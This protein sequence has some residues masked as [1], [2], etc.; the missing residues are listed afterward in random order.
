MQARV[1]LHVVKY[2]YSTGNLLELK[3]CSAGAGS[4]VVP[5]YGAGTYLRKPCS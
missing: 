4:L 3:C 2:R 1:G 5:D